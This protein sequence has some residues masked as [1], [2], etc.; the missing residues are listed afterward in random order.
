[1]TVR[2]KGLLRD[3]AELMRR[4]PTREWLRV[5][6]LLE[7]DKARSQLIAFFREISESSPDE[8]P[9]SRSPQIRR[10][11]RRSPR[12]TESDSRER[13]ELDLSRSSIAEL[14]YMARQYGL[15]FSVKDS[16]ERLTQQILKSARKGIVKKKEQSETLVGQARGDYARWADIII[17][18]PRAR[19]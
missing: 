15:P 8:R 9:L 4:H 10:E 13:F 16:R 7:D 14:R 3:L 5:V 6:R 19:K 12:K 1:M 18:G 17:K 2:P 11:G